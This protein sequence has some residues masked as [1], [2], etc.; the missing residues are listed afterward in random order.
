MRGYVS[1]RSSVAAWESLGLLYLRFEV[2]FRCYGVI[3]LCGGVADVDLRGELRGRNSDGGK[4]HDSLGGCSFGIPLE[5][6]RGTDQ[7]G[8]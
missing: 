1:C 8:G 7:L 6:L 4:T 5:G 2:E 3:H